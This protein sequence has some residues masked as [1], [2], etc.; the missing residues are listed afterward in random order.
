MSIPLAQLQSVMQRSILDGDNATLCFL[1][2][3]PNDTPEVMFGVYKNAYV[4]RLV[5][6]AGHDYEYLETY[7]GEEQFERMARGYVKAHPSRQPNARWFAHGVPEFL[8]AQEPWSRYPEL[9]ELAALERAL[10]DAFD[11]PDAAIFTLADLQSF[12]ASLIGSAELAIHPS[13]RLLKAKTNVASIWS[14]LKS[15]ERPPKPEALAEPIDIL[16]WR[17][18]LASRFRLLGAEEAMAIGEAANSV[19]FGVL[20]EM[21]A[22]MDDPDTA[23]MRAGSYLRGW[24]EAELVSGLAAGGRS[25]RSE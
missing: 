7:L 12:D 25:D 6:V 13:M 23:A 21:I 18:A 22:T 9:A 14:A 2:P 5:E 1:K 3:T 8:A 15:E 17:Q 10:N 4:M 20:C 19:P 11:A 24:I 16:V